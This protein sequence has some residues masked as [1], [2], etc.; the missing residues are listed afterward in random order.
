MET[1]SNAAATAA[2]TASKLLWGEQGTQSNETAGQEPISGQKGKGTVDD[3]YDQ[4]NLGTTNYSFH[5]YQSFLD[6]DIFL[7]TSHL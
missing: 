7:R 2:S 6:S 1:I 3:P 4:G 5:P